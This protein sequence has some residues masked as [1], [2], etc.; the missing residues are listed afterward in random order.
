[1]G[2][3]FQLSPNLSRPVR[4]INSMSG[5]QDALVCVAI[6]ELE[7]LSSRTRLSPSNNESTKIDSELIFFFVG[8][9]V[10]L[11]FGVSGLAR[12]STLRIQGS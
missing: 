10:P 6:D 1:M 9:I 3:E 8:L 2:Q 11:F 4:R 7:K 5:S 12:A